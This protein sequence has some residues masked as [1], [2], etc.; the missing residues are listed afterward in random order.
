MSRSA[1]DVLADVKELTAE[2]YR[3]TGKAFGVTGELAEYAPAEK[4]GL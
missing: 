1:R 4:L 3:A 2:Y